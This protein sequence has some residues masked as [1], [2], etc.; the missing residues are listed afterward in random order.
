MVTKK[1]QQNEE[2]GRIRQL[3]QQMEKREHHTHGDSVKFLKTHNSEE[4]TLGKDK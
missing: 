4:N 2:E 1:K 3:V